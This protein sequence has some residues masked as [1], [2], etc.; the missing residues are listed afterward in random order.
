MSDHSN[1][2]QCKIV[3]RRRW[4]PLLASHLKQIVS[5]MIQMKT[6]NCWVDLEATSMSCKEV[7]E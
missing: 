4:E 7:N 2:H 3:R 1:G 5:L 6:L